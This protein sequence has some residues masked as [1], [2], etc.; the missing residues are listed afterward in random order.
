[1]GAGFSGL[2]LALRLAQEG[3]SFQIWE[4][5]E[6]VGGTWRSNRYPGCGC[7]IPSYLYSLSFAP[8]EGWSQRYASSPEIR[9]Y[10]ESLAKR[11]EI[12]SRLS[13]A[14]RVTSARFEPKTGRWQV[15]DHQ[16]RETSPRYL[17]L[18][19]GPLRVPKFPPIEGRESFQGPS[20][21]TARWD[22]NFA[23][24]GLRLGIVG[25]GASTA[26]LVPALVDTAAKIHVFQRSPAWVLPKKNHPYGSW[27]QAALAHLPGLRRLYRSFL[28]ANQELLVP[29]FQGNARARRLLEDL[30]R[31]HLEEAVQDPELRARL[32]PKTPI[33]CKRILFA[34]GYAEALDRDNVE[35]VTSSL[36]RILP[37]GVELERGREIELDA[38]IY[39]TGFDLSASLLPFPVSG[40]KAPLSEAWSRGPRAFLGMATTGFPN[41]FFLLGPNSGLGH[42]S[43]VFMAECQFEAILRLWRQARSRKLPTISVRDRSETRWSEE[44]ERRL[45][46]SVWASGCQSWYRLED[47]SIPTL[48]PGSTWDFWRRCR[49][50]DES[51]FRFEPEGLPGLK[52]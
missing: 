37:M 30:S 45:E 13:L 1:M 28:W 20:F 34:E 51:D 17:I 50:V 22:S 11:P 5:Q 3:A 7:D 10:L 46:G 19:T 40:P 32:T 15:Q 23:W 31:R 27:A 47:G 35:L 16:G 33:G 26:Q 2:G 41:L 29:A 49:R 6:G 12:A 43:V 8:N 24:K 21:H 52:D 36:S 18:A 9:S 4:A 48:W 14:R 44:L 39:A 25:T 42:N 38:L